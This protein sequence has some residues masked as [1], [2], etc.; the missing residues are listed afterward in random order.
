MSK[1]SK[2][3]VVDYY[4]SDTD[5]TDFKAVSAQDCTGLIPANPTSDYSLESYKQTYDYA[6][7]FKDTNK[8]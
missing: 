1:K 3:K 2:K 7:K 8:A 6:A 5:F 4:G